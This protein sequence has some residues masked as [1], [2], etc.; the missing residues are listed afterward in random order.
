MSTSRTRTEVLNPCLTCGK[1]FDIGGCM[2]FVDH[3]LTELNG[4]KC[5]GC[6]TQVVK[7]VEGGWQPE[8]WERATSLADIRA[9]LIDALDL[10]VRTKNSLA[11]L[12]VV[13]VGDLLDFGAGRIRRELAVAEPVLREVRELLAEKSLPLAEE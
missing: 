13:S 10:S 11:Q 9:V 7:Q 1:R 3:F 5:D 2:T 12:G 6:G 8:V 4:G